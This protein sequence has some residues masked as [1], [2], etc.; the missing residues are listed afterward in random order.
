MTREELVEWLRGKPTTDHMQKAA[1]MLEADGK[2]RA[3]CDRHDQHR[4]EVAE[5][6][7]AELERQ[8]AKALEIDTPEKL[9]AYLKKTGKMRP[10][11]T[12]N[13]I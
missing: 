10:A 1:D 8:L 2:A 3:Y 6:R 5:A 12:D 11:G 4:A 9:A 7:I 13:G